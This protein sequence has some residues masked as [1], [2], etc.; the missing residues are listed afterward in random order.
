[1]ADYYNTFSTII[2][3]ENKAQQ[4]YLMERLD[5][6]N[7]SCYDP[8]LRDDCDPICNYERDGEHVWLYSEHDGLN[9]NVADVIMFFLAEFNRDDKIV[10][11]GAYGCSKLREDE[12]G[13]WACGITSS[14][15]EWVDSHQYMR[16]FLN[17]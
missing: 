13:G 4:D 17:R 1:M 7:E 12:F 16:D 6:L 11:S 9:G 15:V 5:T 2:P 10:I 3:C 8:Y 14:A